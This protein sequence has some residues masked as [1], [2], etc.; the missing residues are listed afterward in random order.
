MDPASLLPEPEAGRWVRLLLITRVLGSVVAVGLLSAHEVT[1]HDDLL[2]LA[3][4]TWG[5]ASC[6]AFA[7]FPAVQRSALAWALDIAIALGLI[8]ASGDWRSPFYIVGLTTLVLPATELRARSGMVWG[9]GYVVAYLGV[10]VAT[11]LPAQTLENSTRLETIVTHLMLPLV[12][13]I[14]LA[15]SAALLRRLASEREQGERLVLE[16]ER[17]RIAWEL[18]DSAKQRLHAANLV[19]SAD[20][21]P[22]ESVRH[23]RRELM[24]AVGDMESAIDELRTPLRNRPLEETLAERATELR[25]MADATITV[26]GAAPELPA[27]TAAHVHRIAAEALTNAVRH[28][29]ATTIDI[30]I[31]R[32]DDVL[33]IRISDDGC[34]LPATIRPGAHGLRAMAGRA[35]TIGARLRIAPRLDH[36]GTDVTLTLPLSRNG[37]AP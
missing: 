25:P 7:R 17:R 32:R 2:V 3:A 13:A 26:R 15:Y 31:D 19:L 20:P 34:G 8:Y 36:A 6:V 30:A 37:A 33:C 11:R 5:A 16:A 18:H 10:A 29:N 21:D 22:P 14:A 28:A 23:A 1:D 9:G 24:A 27:T 35:E 12:V 4:I